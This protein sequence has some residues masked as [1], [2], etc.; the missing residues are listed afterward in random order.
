MAAQ[1]IRASQPFWALRTTLAETTLDTLEAQFPRRS[2]VDKSTTGLSFL[3]T[4]RILEV[5][6]EVGRED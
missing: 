2:A 6:T 3:L 4:G 5:G 1:R